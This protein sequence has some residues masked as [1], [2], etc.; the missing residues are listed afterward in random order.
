MSQMAVET[1]VAGGNILPA[2]FVTPVNGTEFTVVQAVATGILCGIAN[3]GTYYAPGTPADNGYAGISPY[4]FRVYGPG[5]EAL[6]EI[7]ASVNA[8]DYLCSDSVGRGV[9]CVLTATTHQDIGA[10][11]LQTDA[12]VGAKIRVRVVQI[13]ARQT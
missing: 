1:Y 7:G 12:N 8:G 10:I 3:N 4:L 13:P 9:T 6:L 2:R 5:E 11:A